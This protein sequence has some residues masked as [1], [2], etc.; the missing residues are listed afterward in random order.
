MSRSCFVLMMV[1]NCTWEQSFS[2]MG[3]VKSV[4]RSKMG[5]ERLYVVINEYRT[6]S[7]FVQSTW[8]C[9]RQ[10]CTQKGPQGFVVTSVLT[11]ECR[12]RDRKCTLDLVICYCW[13]MVDTVI[14]CRLNNANTTH[15]LIHH[16]VVDYNA[17]ARFQLAF[18]CNSPT[19]KLTSIIKH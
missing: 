7:P 12:C 8:W 10:L 2:W 15:I 19:N 6:R 16:G 18:Y 11:S 1:S 4:L 3:F 9:R 17:I 5:Q 13:L 14:L